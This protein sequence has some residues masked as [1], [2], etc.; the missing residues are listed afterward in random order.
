MKRFVLGNN[1]FVMSELKQH[2]GG[3]PNDVLALKKLHT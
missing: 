2:R 3:I 1:S